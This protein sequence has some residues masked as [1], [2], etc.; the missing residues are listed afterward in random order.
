MEMTSRESDLPWSTQRP[1]DQPPPP[2]SIPGPLFPKIQVSAQPSSGLCSRF[3]N[4]WSPLK[5][6]W[7][8]SSRM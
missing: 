5:T 3:L 4:C 2:A 7:S 8:V 6:E 1:P